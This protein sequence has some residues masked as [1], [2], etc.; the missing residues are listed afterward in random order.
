M[1]AVVLVGNTKYD[2]K[3]QNHRVICYEF[4]INL[5][6]ARTIFNSS[7]PLGS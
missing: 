5:P 4:I 1:I 3:S 7:P 6:R 2:L